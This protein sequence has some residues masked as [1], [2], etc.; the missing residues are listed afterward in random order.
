M[1]DCRSALCS[2]PSGPSTSGPPPAPN[3]I[4]P[5][6]SKSRL[7]S[8][9]SRRS[10]RRHPGS[11][12]C[13]GALPDHHESIGLRIGKRTNQRGV[14]QREHRAVGADAERECER[15]D[16]RKGRGAFQLSQRKRHIRLAFVEPLR[17]AHLAISL[18][19]KVD[20][21]AFELPDIANP[22]QDDVA[23]GLR[24]E[25]ALHE[26]AGPQLDMQ[27]EFLIHFLIERDTP[28]P[29]T[30]GVSSSILTYGW[31]PSDGISVGR[32]SV[33]SRPP[34]SIRSCRHCASRIFETPAAN[35]RHAAVSAASCARPCRVRR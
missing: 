28:E 18:S 34:R 30:K 29:R 33:G 22:R 26:L 9:Q 4:P 16:R 5:N 13:W 32:S 10:R 12:E 23:R 8:T 31:P 19:A 3:A 11:R 21:R 1:T 7:C 2:E 6:T 24:V 25:A 27:G 15:G 35:C 17:E 20:T 14:G